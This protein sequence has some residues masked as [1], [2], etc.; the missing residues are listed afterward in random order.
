MDN[1]YNILTVLSVLL[2]LAAFLLAV[3]YLRDI[4]AQI[5]QPHERTPDGLPEKFYQED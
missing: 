5:F 2:F 1:P 3:C 4:T